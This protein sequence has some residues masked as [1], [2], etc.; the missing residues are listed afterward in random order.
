MCWTSSGGSQLQALQHT[1]K[2]FPT[3]KFHQRQFVGPIGVQDVG[4]DL[5]QKAQLA[6]FSWAL[7]LLLWC[8]S[9]TCESLLWVLSGICAKFIM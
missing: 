4:R 1:P 7:S 5:A 6:P 3:P 2:I 8:S 9:K